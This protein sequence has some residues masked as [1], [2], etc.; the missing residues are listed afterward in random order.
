M[1]SDLVQIVAYLNPER[2]D[3]AALA[4]L[5][6]ALPGGRRS[7]FARA[8]ITIA[9]TDAQA[10]PISCDVLASA[11]DLDSDMLRDEMRR[12]FRGGE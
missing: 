8:C 6:D 10:S 4:R 3:H 1:K 11:A 2:A 9:V 12:A 7:R 5:L